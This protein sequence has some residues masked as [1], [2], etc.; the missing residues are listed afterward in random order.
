M[1]ARKNLHLRSLT[2]IC[3]A[4][5]AIVWILWWAQVFIIWTPELKCQAWVAWTRRAPESPNIV[6]LAIDAASQAVDAN[7]SDLASSPALQIMKQEFPWSR[8]VYALIL[9]RLISAGASCVA[10]DMRF[11]TGRAGDDAFR[12][13]LDRYRDHVVIGFNFPD[14]E[15]GAAKTDAIEW[16]SETLIPVHHT[17]TGEADDQRDGDPRLGFVTVWADAD[18]IVRHFWFRRTF[19]QVINQPPII[20]EPVYESLAAR[21]VRQAGF[22][23][24]IPK[25][26][27]GHRIRYAYWDPNQASNFQAH[28]LFEIF[29]P[30]V[31]EKN[32][33]NGA[34]F[35]NKI[36]VIGPSG[37]WS[38]DTIQTPFGSIEGALYH[39]NAIN[40]ILNRQYLAESTKAV[41]YTLF[42]LSAALAWALGFFIRHPVFRSFLLI[43]AVVGWCFTT[44]ALYSGGI[45]VPVFAPVAI[46]AASVMIFMVF[47]FLL[48]QRER[49]RIR[50]TL[51]GYVSKDVVKE[52]L[53]N[54]E[55]YLHSA[56]GA[57]KRISILFSDVRGFTSMTEGADAHK[58]VEQLNEYFTEMV[59]IVFAHDGTMDK[60]IG[61]AV[62]A[63]WGGIITHGEQRDACHAV[64]TA[65][66]MLTEVSRLNAG[67]KER[68]LHELRIGV[69]VNCGDAICGKLGSPEKHDFTVIGDPVNLASRLE[70]ATKGLNVDLL[71]G[72]TVAPLVKH[73]FILRTVDLLQV[74]GKTKPV[75]VFTALGER[76]NMEEPA[77]LAPYE[78]GIRL[79]RQRQFGNAI[80]R[81]EIAAA[82]LPGDWLI[83]EYLRRS[84]EFEINAPSAEWD[85]VMVLTRK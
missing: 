55:S 65:L 53:D 8:E 35:R 78:E 43:G 21:A 9:D 66:Q 74:S 22:A 60:F 51:E 71:I 64:S 37:S 46:T 47:E 49:L 69:G 28:S 13:A 81:F 5:L 70:S 38:K 59:R 34:F 33:R 50:Q 11:P 82:A 17:E 18:E 20:G 83:Q 73:R 76:K 30:G 39:I 10:I 29:I 4:C 31:W 41:N 14:Q 57:R 48:E 63:H 12:T 44:A 40:A 27:K 26:P 80:A 7:E 62:M 19:M 1:P 6:Y 61:D 84:R 23:D 75:E 79:Y 45:I 2:I 25:E 15:S 56:S 77:W 58:L 42:I 32:Y 67:W 52:V 54:P 16:P 36:V 72:E 68:N 24:L 3:V 85:G